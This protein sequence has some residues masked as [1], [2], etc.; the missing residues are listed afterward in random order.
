MKDSFGWRNTVL[1]ALA[2]VVEG[3]G[4]ASLEDAMLSI[5]SPLGRA[6]KLPK[7]LCTVK[8]FPDTAKEITTYFDGERYGEAEPLLLW[9][10][11]TA[12]S[13]AATYEADGDWDGACK[14]YIELCRTY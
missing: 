10:L 7:Y 3:A 1:D 5:A 12:E 8:V 2:D 14:V 6:R 4:L 13:A 11:D 9:L